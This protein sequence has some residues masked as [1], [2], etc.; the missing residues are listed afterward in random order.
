MPRIAL[1]LTPDELSDVM[2]LRLVLRK[3]G[4]LKMDLRLRVAL[5][6]LNTVIK[7]DELSIQW[8]IEEIDK[9]EMMIRRTI[10]V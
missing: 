4:R 6:F 2:G 3:E 7:L 10:P 8:S 5:E 9:R 1:R